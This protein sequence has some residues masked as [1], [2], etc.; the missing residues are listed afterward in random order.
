MIQNWDEM[1]NF[2]NTMQGCSLAGAPL[3]AK[4]HQ[5]VRM[6]N[7]LFMEVAELQDS[8]SW[9]IARDV[10][11]VEEPTIDRENV[12]REIVDCLFFLHHIGEC[13][14]IRPVD[15]NHTFNEVMANNKKRHIDGDFSSEEEK[16]SHYETSL[17]R[18]N[19]KLDK[20]ING[21]FDK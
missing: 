15:L 4:V 12:K 2:Q 7:G 17:E 16:E 19:A 13:F 3:K 20:L 21:D 5:A 9:K 14:G 1:T 11:R 10:N 18:I 6:C 8:F